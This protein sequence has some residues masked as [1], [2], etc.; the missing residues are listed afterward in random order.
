MITLENFKELAKYTDSSKVGKAALELSSSDIKY[1]I[2]LYDMLGE[3]KLNISKEH[4]D[5]VV[6]SYIK[7][8]LIENKIAIEKLVESEEFRMKI[9]SLTDKELA[10]YMEL[11]DKDESND[12]L[13]NGIIISN[14]N[15][16]DHFTII[17]MGPEIYSK[18]TEIKNIFFAAINNKCPISYIKT[19]IKSVENILTP[20]NTNDL[21]RLLVS[22]D[23]YKYSNIT[24]IEIIAEIGAIQ[25]ERILKLLVDIALAGYW[26]H[27]FTF[28]Q[29]VELAQTTSLNNQSLLEKETTY[30]KSY[31]DIV[32]MLGITEISPHLVTLFAN[33]TINN[34]LSYEQ[35]IN[36]IQNYDLNSE[37][38]Y[39]KFAALLSK[40]IKRGIKNNLYDDLCTKLN[41][42][43]YEQTISEYLNECNSINEVIK[44][45]ES[46]FKNTDFID[47]NAILTLKNF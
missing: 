24:M 3:E 36:L 26:E 43:V 1:V 34:N 30:E 33:E 18:K 32:E 45:L 38:N 23:F 40:I 15:V 7:Q 31:E 19:L 28:K 4:I 2:R 21:T 46:N 17:E 10:K 22:T 47:P 35:I 16:E 25:D 6:E 29:V 12:L 37:E 8:R 5:I 44:T 20:V 11:C 39:D 9:A 13:T 27:A 42:D 14:Y 41:E